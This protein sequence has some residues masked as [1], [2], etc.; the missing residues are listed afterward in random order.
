MIK[1][2]LLVLILVLIPTQAWSFSCPSLMVKIDNA[3]ASA[4]INSERLEV[5]R[6]LRN[7]GEIFHSL[8]D[9]NASEVTLNAA[10]DLL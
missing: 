9:H 7:K 4:E 10:I 1:K 8:G 5:I 6:F 3:M 2:I